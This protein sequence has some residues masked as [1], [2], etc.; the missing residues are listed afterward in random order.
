MTNV[1]GMTFQGCITAQGFLLKVYQQLQGWMY[2]IWLL[3]WL[4]AFCHLML[5]FSGESPILVMLGQA[6]MHRVKKI[7]AAFK[8]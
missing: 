2:T 1:D 3:A 5:G 8:F 4:V 7:T 6:Q